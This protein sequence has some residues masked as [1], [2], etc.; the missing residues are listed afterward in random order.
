MSTEKFTL[1]CAVH[2]FLIRDGKTLLLRRYNTGWRDGEYS[3]IAGHIDGKESIRD[4]MVREAKEESGIDVHENDLIVV[5]TMHRNAGDREYIDFFLTTEKWAGEP[6]IT[7]ND[8]CDD[9]SW[10]PL[11][12]LPE[13]MI[14][15]IRAALD[16]FRNGKTF[17]E[18]GWR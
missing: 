9:L 8:K 17:S 15:Y 14:P 1:R 18:F 10:F 4:A 7:E 13:N 5:H 16:A 3:V 12:D 6:H 11:V 2:L